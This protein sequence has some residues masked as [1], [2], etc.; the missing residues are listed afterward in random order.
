MQQFLYILACLTIP[1][2]WGAIVNW[3]FDRFDK[4]ERRESPLNDFQ[5]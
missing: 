5:I 4:G 3:I 2:V 1:I